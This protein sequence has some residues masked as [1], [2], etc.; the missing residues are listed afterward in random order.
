[1]N[2][3]LIEETEFI[4]RDSLHFFIYGDKLNDVVKNNNLN[5]VVF[6]SDIFIE[7]E[8]LIFQIKFL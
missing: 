5:F 1:M 3:L 7:F 2:E 8:T 4:I 6:R